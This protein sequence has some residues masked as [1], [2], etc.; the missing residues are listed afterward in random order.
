[1]QLPIY[2]RRAARRSPRRPCGFL[3][4]DLDQGGRHNESFEGFT[5]RR[6]SRGVASSPRPIPVVDPEPGGGV[7]RWHGWKVG[8]VAAVVVPLAF[9]A[10]AAAVPWSVTPSPNR[11]SD[12]NAL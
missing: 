7:M 8:M 11:N 1:M 12:L 5:G 6:W 9:A 3:T 2:A 4:A 10:N